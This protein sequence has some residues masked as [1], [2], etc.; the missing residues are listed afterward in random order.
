[1]DLPVMAKGTVVL[2]TIN[3]VFHPKSF[4]VLKCAYILKSWETLSPYFNFL[5]WRS[6]TSEVTKRCNQ[7]LCPI[8]GE[9]EKWIA[10]Y[11][12]CNRWNDQ[13]VNFTVGCFKVRK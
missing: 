11:L 4:E 13:S 10:F 5:M 9:K 8:K 7:P 3:L 12:V 1:M 6:M 2:F